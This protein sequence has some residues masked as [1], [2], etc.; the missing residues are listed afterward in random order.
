MK[1]FEIDIINQKIAK[2]LIIK[3]HYSHKWTSCRYAFGLIL[4]NKIVG[5]CVYGC[6]VGRLA[7]QSISKIVEPEN[8]LELTRLWV[9]DSEGKNT[10][11]F[12]IGQTFQW[13]RR[14][15]KSIK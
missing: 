11:S 15:D 2:D 14:F 3:N 13:L 8:T 4:N 6:P 1:N 10:E 12:F 5:V 7:A 9:N